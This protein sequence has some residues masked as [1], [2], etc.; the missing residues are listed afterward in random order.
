M[1]S[2]TLQKLSDIL[3]TLIGQESAEK[4]RDSNSINALLTSVLVSYRDRKL[5][6]DVSL[7]QDGITETIVVGK[8]FHA[9][10]SM[11][12]RNPSL[13]ID[14]NRHITILQ[15]IFPFLNCLNCSI[16]LI[17]DALFTLVQISS[18][19]FKRGLLS[20]NRLIFQQRDYIFKYLDRLLS[21]IIRSFTNHS[22]STLPIVDVKSSEVLSSL[23]SVEKF[24]N[25]YYDKIAKVS[26]VIKIVQFLTHPNINKL[27]F[28]QFHTSLILD[29]YI[30][31]C[32]FCLENIIV[33]INFAPEND[34]IISLL[35]SLYSTLLLST[36]NYYYNDPTFQFNRLQLAVKSCHF[37]LNW[38]L[39]SK[40]NNLQIILAQCLMKL[41][42]HL[43]SLNNVEYLWTNIG[44][45][46]SSIN[47]FTELIKKVSHPELKYCLQ[48]MLKA[49]F[50]DN[51]NYVKNVNFL[52]KT[53]G[54]DTVELQ[55]LEKVVGVS[56]FKKDIKIENYSNNLTFDL[57]QKFDNTLSDIKSSLLNLNE[58]DIIKLL[59]SLGDYA[60]YLSNHYDTSSGTCALCD[61]NY[62]ISSYIVGIVDIN[63]K[64][65]SLDSKA[66]EV[67]SVL[68]LCANKYVNSHKY[69]I[70]ISLL[71]SLTKLL[72]NFRLTALSENK[73]IW[74]FVQTCFM[75]PLREI[76]ILSVKIIPLFV[77]TP[78]DQQC[79][80]D[81]DLIL[82]FLFQFH[83][84][85][86]KN[87]FYTFEGHIM[88]LGELLIVKSIDTRY[89][90]IL[91]Q[92]IKFMSDADEFR[93]NMAIYQ[94]RMVAHTK[95]ITPW[96]LVEPF[97][98]IISR[99]IVKNRNSNP[100]ILTNFCVAIE[101]N[102][103]LFLERT[104]KYTIPFLIN[105]YNEDHISFIAT[106]TK[107][108]KSDLIKSQ[109]DEILAYLF[110][111]YG[112]ISHKKILNILSIYD[113]SYKSVSFN[114]LL[115]ACKGPYFLHNLLY[116]YNSEPETFERIKKAIGIISVSIKYDSDETIATQKML[117]RWL[118][119]IVQ[120]VSTTLNDKKG[121]NPYTVKIRAIKSIVCL[122]ELCSNFEVCLGQVITA[123][124]IALKFSELRS[125]A[126]Y[127]L[128]L[129]INKVDPKSVEFIFDSLL[130]QFIQQ[131]ES[132]SEEN[133]KITTEII[134]LLLKSVP[135]KD[136]SYRYALQKIP[137]LKNIKFQHVSDRRIIADFRIRLKSDN[138]WILE[139]V[140]DDL[141]EYLV[142]GQV[143]YQQVIKDD[144]LLLNSFLNIIEILVS[145]SFKNYN[146]NNNNNNLNNV[147]NDNNMEDSQIA[148]KSAKVI[149]LLG[150]LDLT[151]SRSTSTSHRL[152][153]SNAYD[154]VTNFLLVTNL[155]K[156]QSSGQDSSTVE[157]S[158]YFLKNILVRYFVS[159]VDPEEQKYL[160]YT[161]Q[162]YLS[163]FE[164][165]S[166]VWDNFDSLTKNIL[167]PLKITR[168]KQNLKIRL[169][170]FPIYKSGKDYS[171]WLRELTANLLH[172]CAGLAEAVFKA[173]VSM[174]SICSIIPILDIGVSKFVLPYAILFLVVIEP[175]NNIYKKQ[176]QKEL[177]NILQHDLNSINNEVIKGNLKKCIVLI[178]EIFQFLKAWNNKVK[179]EEEESKSNNKM[180]SKIKRT[181][182]QRVE[183]FLNAFPTNILAKRCAECDLYE[184]S[185]LHL[186]ESFKQNV[187][188][189][190]DFFSTLKDM[191]VQLEDY[192][193]LHGALKTF[194]TNSLNDKLLQFKYNSDTQISNESLDAIAQYD[195]DELK[196]ETVEN[197]TIKKSSVT[198]LFE[199]LNKNCE[200]DQL[201]LNLKNYELKMKTKNQEINPEWILYGIQA[202][203][204]TGD[205]KD[206]EKWSA[207]SQESNNIAFPGLD[208]SIYYE[209]AQALISLHYSNSPLC[210][211]H[212]EN[213]VKSIGMAISNSE[214]LIHKKI[215][216]YMV[217][218]HSLYDFQLL[219]K[220]DRRNDSI[221]QHL[222][223]RLKNSKQDFKSIWKIH[224]MKSSIYKL[225]PGQDFQELY[226]DSLIEGCQILRENGKLPQATKLITKALVLNDNDTNGEM[227]Q[228]ST[229]LMNVEFSKLFW[230]QN[231]YET[232]L[233]NMGLVIENLDFK[234]PYYLDF[235]LTYLTWL[236]VSAE[237]SSDEIMKKYSSLLHDTKFEH[238]AEI[239][240][241]YAVYL[242]KLLE[243]QVVQESDGSLDIS[244]IKYYIL[245]VK[246]SQQYVHETMPKAVTLWLAYYEKYLIVGHD[247]VVSRKLVD[248]R[249]NIYQKINLLLE[250]CVTELGNK[251]YIVL[252]QLLS[253]I[254]HDD[255]KI[256]DLISK[257]I[258]ELTVKY[259]WLLLYSVFAQ[260][261]SVDNQRRAIGT[262]LLTKLQDTR[263]TRDNKS[264]QLPKLVSSGLILL[265]SIMAVCNI[266][267]S[268][269]HP[270][271]GVLF[272]NLYKDLNFNYPRDSECLSL[273]LP[274]KYNMDLLY[275]LRN[276][277]DKR[278]VFYK[279]FHEKVKILFSLQ[280]PKRIK[281]TGTNGF[282]YF[283]LFKPR[284]DLRKDN[285]VMEF[286]TVMNGLLM[287]NY[288][289][290]TR[291]MQIKSFAATPLNE[292]TGIIEWVQNFVTLRPIIEKRL[293]RK[294]ITLNLRNMKNE[295]GGAKDNEKLNVYK[296]YVA[297]YPPVLGDW[298]I[299]NCPNISEW[300]RTRSLYTRSLAVMS[301]VGYLIGVG[302]RHLD[303]IMLNINTGMIMHIDFDCIFE[304]G[305]KLGVPE[306]VPFRLT[307][308]LIEAMGALK[309]EGSFR[310]SCE[311]TMSI[312]RDNENILMNFLESFIHDPLMDWRSSANG[313][314]R[315]EEKN[316][317]RIRKQQEI[318]YKTLRRKIRGILSK[319]DDN[320][321]H[322]DSGGLS[323]SVS[324]QVE[325]LIQTAVSSE[326]LSKMFFGWMPFL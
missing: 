292:T 311:L 88:C 103:A 210:L 163:I 65:I 105:S 142:N 27:F 310:K 7:A 320:T 205:I 202:S 252:S 185:I 124:Q 256:T 248:L 128:K 216:E 132:F 108:S 60:C 283:L 260:A 70:V 273:A 232:A 281:I 122:L 44:I 115:Y 38:S 218:L 85:N 32:W 40:F 76:R 208:I 268:Y 224:S 206:L 214:N 183:K 286:S 243:A 229:L 34:H 184:G 297:K 47:Y 3:D 90:I 148:Q 62:C 171:N 215:P 251:W 294:N 196:E 2:E 212:I 254:T 269:K 266:S 42:V 158:L 165:P 287:R 211:E 259:P 129:I 69:N 236:D 307:P 13:L 309:Y 151:L 235:S 175:E 177:M 147:S 181:G 265:E 295:F 101:M 258:I 240:Y 5:D 143:K 130:S 92:L 274:I 239:F 26:I 169:T 145:N 301:I 174:T 242:N 278:V 226:K 24:S 249:T 119:I 314:A 46:D 317:L 121:S 87:Y 126:L 188:E 152:F 107:K 315:S 36:V 190:D 95:Q 223:K 319:D 82:S 135:H 10:K 94:L 192:D 140:L 198:E 299:E 322:R 55:S 167:E 48:L 323:V 20:Y 144:E 275:N 64:Q 102:V 230:A 253:R 99:D 109:L 98:P 83:P 79:E 225:H 154:N 200:Y 67:Y 318:V 139:Q 91:N 18:E 93:S 123:L 138:K 50:K 133:Q 293:K 193:Q 136:I 106:V 14:T 179:E 61:N 54:F 289:T 282:T 276:D 255:K 22:T 116:H 187:I 9:L 303:N 4:Q 58:I 17:D 241:Q 217:L 161:I 264:A 118:L 291:N 112:N 321:A 66:Q 57:V 270:K 166:S 186:E 15:S 141:I 228:A 176:L 153:S 305:K 300:Y 285:K 219:A 222:K 263:N 1:S 137:S 267:N 104:L 325:L 316:Q 182:I 157:F 30:S 272:K 41:A 201:I 80:Q 150:N 284:D 288:E 74:N 37:L 159:S 111:T 63:R 233:K 173:P 324:L 73:T 326:N 279:R 296:S 204:F 207:L 220:M 180:N 246:Y 125:E 170:E 43:E 271:S 308:N 56:L 194:S 221:T 298:M 261:R 84:K 172:R 110:A 28:I 35:D 117:N 23:L 120:M 68:E 16:E 213:A 280:Q 306:I 51:L 199:V 277:V 209:I 11:F 49:K 227:T 290:Q 78:L 29:S 75:H 245:A 195:F 191:Y 155:Q 96:Q 45:T 168:Y 244:V 131:F 8:I 237:G 89:Y 160:A 127:C 203:I 302:D 247:S 81:L 100:G 178:F 21:E 197:K 313:D 304:K 164:I 189:K 12:S 59:A 257:I 72:R 312:I 149:S 77:Y 162:E 31:K 71:I 19:C 146:D 238:S 86:S 33:N 262:K 39:L 25:I 234:N 250:K 53:P 231:D 52:G 113:P 114:E 134:L 156:H 97:I 6:A